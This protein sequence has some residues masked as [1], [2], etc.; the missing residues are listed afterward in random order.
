MNRKEIKSLIDLAAG[1]LPSIQ[2][3]ELIEIGN[4]W[5]EMLGFLPYQLARDAVKR[6]LRGA[7][8]W[9]T[10]S[11]ILDAAEVIKEERQ[12]RTYRPGEK[13][14][15]PNCEGMG[16]IA[17]M[18]DGEERYARCPCV[19]GENYSGLPMAPGWAITSDRSILQGQVVE[20]IP[21]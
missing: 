16:F 7:R 6:V 10:V 17:I 1:S 18:Q 11:E 8:F 5:E 13:T 15:C 3:K 14:N 9:P 12:R 2:K 19:A 20:D 4:T 21:F